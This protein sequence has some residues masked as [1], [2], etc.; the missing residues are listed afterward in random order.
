MATLSLLAPLTDGHLQT[1]ITLRRV[2]TGGG[3]LIE[4]IMHQHFRSK[5][6]RDSRNTFTNAACVSKDYKELVVELLYLAT[7]STVVTKGDEEEASVWADE[8]RKYFSRSESV[9]RT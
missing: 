2:W 5:Q 3:V 1:P 6:I 4:P 8:G 7:M 9:E